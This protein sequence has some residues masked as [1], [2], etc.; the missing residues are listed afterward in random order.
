[1]CYKCGKTGHESFQCKT[2]QKI[3]ELFSEE[4]ELQ[5]KLLSLLIQ[6]KSEVEDDYYSETSTDSEYEPS[7]ITTLNVITNKSQKEFLLDLISQ[8]PDGQMK[9]EY[10]EKLKTLI[11]E[12]KD[13]G[14]RFSLNGPS[15][16]L[17]NIYKE[18]PI[19]NPLQ[20]ITT[21][22][23]QT[24]INELEKQVKYL[25]DE[26][27]KLKT[28]YLT[29]EA[30]VALLKSQISNPEILHPYQ[31]TF[32]EFPILKSLLLNFYKQFRKLHFKN[33]ILLLI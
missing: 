17:S 20:Q 16:S 5:K 24:E 29:I 22:D 30:R 3:N 25:K 4:P 32:L 23:L 19:S 1:V 6:D 13:K 14:P 18:F 2:E 28:T 15:S 12:E 31:R 9:R 10:L 26:V 7:P 27:T 21:K 33:G 11:L 8:I